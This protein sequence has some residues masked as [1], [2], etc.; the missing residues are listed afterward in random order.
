MSQQNVTTNEF[1]VMTLNGNTAAFETEIEM[2]YMKS[3]RISIA[4]DGFEVG[5]ERMHAF[6]AWMNVNHQGFK[7]SLE[8]EIQNYDLV[9]DDV[10][11]SILG[12]EWTDADEGFLEKHLNYESVD[13]NRG[14]I[15]MWIDTSGLH[16]DHMIRVTMN[17]AIE[18]ECCEML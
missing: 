14:S 2:P 10:W 17:E 12:K 11:D 1:G 18:I 16:T 9:L 13:F 15:Y 3:G 8:R 4:A 5:L 6:V 7:L